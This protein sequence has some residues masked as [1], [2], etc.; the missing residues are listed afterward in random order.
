MRQIEV[1]SLAV[2]SRGEPV[3]ILRPIDAA[4]PNRLLPI[5]IGVQEANAIMLAVEGESAARPMSYDLMARLLESLDSTV[6]KVAVTRLEG[7]TYF[8]E[9]TLATPHGDKVIDARPSDSIALAMRTN[10]PI[11]VADEVL[12]EA[13][14]EDEESEEEAADA[15]PEEQETAIEE[16]SRFLEDVD[17]DDFRG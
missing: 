10:A 3:V 15:M 11:Y 13:G 17:P 12:D 4:T 6:A 5:W 16:F 8:A 7:G 2:D 1:A 14:V 9:V